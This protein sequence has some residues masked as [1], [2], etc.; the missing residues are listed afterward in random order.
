MIGNVIFIG[1]LAV[2][3]ICSMRDLRYGVGMMIAELI[4]GSHGYLISFATDGLSIS[5]RM[6]LF[7]VIVTVAAVQAV[8]ERSLRVY[9][10]PV[11]LPFVA[12][13]ACL[14]YALIRGIAMGNGFANVFFDANAFVYFAAAI[15]FW[16]AVRAREDVVLLAQIALGALLASVTKV[17]FLTYFFAHE[18]NFWYIIGDAYRWVRDTRIGE[19]TEMT[20]LFFR[21]FFQSQIYTSMAWFVVLMLSMVIAAS[22]SVRSLLRDRK[23]LFTFF[24]LTLLTSSTL[25]SLSRSNWLGMVVGFLVMVVAFLWLLPR[26]MPRVV[27]AFAVSAVAAVTSLALITVLVLFP[28]PPV[29]GSFSAGS[30]F[31]K[32]AL[33]FTDEAG[34]GSRWNLLPP[35]W[36]AIA[37]HPVLGQGFGKEVTY[38]T[39]DHRLLAQNPTGQYTTFIFEW[40]YHDLWLKLGLFGL[41]AYAW[42]ILGCLWRAWRWLAARR[43]QELTYD[44]AL[45]LGLSISFIALLVTHTFSPYLNHPLGIGYLLLYAILLEIFIGKRPYSI[46]RTP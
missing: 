24:F 10:S 45:V 37:K 31:S 17:L 16:Q 23:W 26:P 34:V 20:D 27:Y 38:Q 1:I 44:T 9:Q 39:E 19:L 40:G 29:S 4:I 28:F 21:V 11:F 22:A 35:L 6:G 36:T 2:A 30:L 5:L 42:I 3:L 18:L 14:V 25:V 15:P 7:M 41:A 32:R 33:T 46:D 13:A 8:R 12:L 43:G